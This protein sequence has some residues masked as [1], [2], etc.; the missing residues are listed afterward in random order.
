MLGL[1]GAGVAVA[2][3]GAV[4]GYVAGTSSPSPG[5]T[6]AEQVIPFRNTHQAGIVTPQQDRLHFAALDLTTGDPATVQ[7]V[8]RNWTS[9]AERLS[10]G[11]E[12]AENGVQPRN[13]EAPPADTGE[14]ADLPA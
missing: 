5:M 1:T 11:E 2:G 9:M 10:R 8:L 3:A 13:P 4:S 6:P 12:T 14:A 7:R